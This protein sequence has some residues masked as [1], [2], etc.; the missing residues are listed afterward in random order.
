MKVIIVKD[1]KKHFW[2]KQRRS[3]FKDLLFPEYKL[4]KAVDGVSFEVSKGEIV[5][6]LGPNGAGKSTT[7]KV[8]VGILYPTSGKVLV[9]N[10]IP[11]EDRK[12]LMKKIGVVFGQRRFLWPTLSLRDNLEMVGTMYGLSDEEIRERIIELDEILHIKEFID[13]PMRKLSL[14]QQMRGELAAA[15]IHRPEILFLDEPTIG[16]DLLSKLRVIDFLKEI[17][18]TEKVTIFHTSH[19]LQEVQRLCE[20]IIVINRG[21]ILYDGPLEKIRPNKVLVKIQTL[22]EKE[23]IEEIPRSKIREFLANLPENVVDVE[24]QEIPIEEVIKEFYQ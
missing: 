18:K 1:L 2:V 16:M 19:D 8:L 7:I 4:V 17:N 12:E 15:L 11:W 5:G 10:K 20:R 22:D 6:F 3:F 24:I 9:D 13:A 21:K 23:I 14:G